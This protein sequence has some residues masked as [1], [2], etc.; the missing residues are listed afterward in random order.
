MQGKNPEKKKCAVYRKRQN[1]LQ[2]TERF[3]EFIEGVVV[4][5]TVKIV[6]GDV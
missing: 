4:Q 3:Q 5:K 2:E 6:A 1:G